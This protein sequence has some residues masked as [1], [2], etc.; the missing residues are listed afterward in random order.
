MRGSWTPVSTL[1]KGLFA[2]GFSL[3][4]TGCNTPGFGSQGGHESSAGAPYCV[5]EGIQ[6]PASH[7]LGLRDPIDCVDVDAHQDYE[8]FHVGIA[9]WGSKGGVMPNF[10]LPVN[11][12]DA[13]QIG[14]DYE[15]SSTMSILPKDETARD[16]EV[17]GKV[18]FAQVGYA[19]GDTVQG[20]LTLEATNHVDGSVKNAT[21]E[22][23]AA[24]RQQ[25]E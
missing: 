8:A 25:D 13:L 21:I 16:M 12:S 6:L 9:L 1:I 22:F 4:A 20:T 2:L 11:D 15:V 18:V 14:K 5:F 7:D 17:L 23:T 19:T 24:V 3:L 10:Y